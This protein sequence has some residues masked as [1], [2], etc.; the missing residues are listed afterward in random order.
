MEKSLAS[1]VTLY[2]YIT[3]FMSR[4]KEF[5]GSAGP[6]SPGHTEDWLERVAVGASLLCLLHCLALPLLIAA[7][8]AL[9]R[10]LAIP[11]SFHLLM[12][13]I[14]IP[15]SGVALLMGRTRHGRL[16]PL[17]VGMAGLACL[18]IATLFFELTPLELPVTVVGSL[19]LAVAHV[20]NWRLRH[21]QHRH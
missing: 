18:T 17:L 15:S 9:S 21:A 16:W 3:M 10:L 20:A 11:E 19:A 8:P 7:L 1:Q 13:L 5:V 2:H 4:N 6:A 14:A 12:L